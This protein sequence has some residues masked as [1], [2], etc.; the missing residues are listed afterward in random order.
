MDKPLVINLTEPWNEKEI[1]KLIESLP[2]S[3]ETRSLLEINNKL[4]SKLFS[5]LEK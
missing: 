5:T 3:E 2:T 1:S 4:F